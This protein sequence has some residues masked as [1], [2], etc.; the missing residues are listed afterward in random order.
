VKIDRPQNIEEAIERLG[1]KNRAA[2]LFNEAINPKMAQ[3][4]ERFLFLAEAIDGLKE[5]IRKTPN[6][7]LLRLIT[8]IAYEHKNRDEEARNYYRQAILLDKASVHPFPLTPRSIEAYR[9]RQGLKPD[10]LNPELSH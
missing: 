1:K 6:D 5:E 3:K 4:P 8:A 9:R 10:L 7:P 2:G